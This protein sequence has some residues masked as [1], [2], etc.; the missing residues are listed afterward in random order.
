ME[1]DQ[2]PAKGTEQET[3]SETEVDETTQN[4][5]VEETLNPETPEIPTE[6]TESTET[7]TE[8]EQPDYKQKFVESSKES[9]LNAERVRLAQD[10]IEKLTKYDTPTDEFMREAY[11][12]WDTFNEVTQK[13][14]MKT[15]AQELRQHRIEAQQ[16]DILAQ[17]KLE[18]ELTDVFIS[19]PQ[20]A[21]KEADFKRFAMNPKNKGISVDVLAKAYLFD[22]EEEQ[23]KPQQGAAIPQGNG[24]SREP[25]KQK[26]VSL[27]EARIIRETDPQR[28]RELVQQDMI[29]TE[30]E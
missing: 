17:M 29:E 13:A 7:D 25:L 1:N 20:L 6:A 4:K 16:A 14:L 18:R 9:I 22:A 27:E 28:H 5:S 23:P 19:N 21:G 3:Q 2:T 30:L 11:P 10:Q 15:E 12:E 24:G 8:P 26:K